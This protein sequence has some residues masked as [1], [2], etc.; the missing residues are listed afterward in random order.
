MRS[1]GTIAGM[2]ALA[3][4]GLSLPEMAGA[5]AVSIGVQT[6]NMQLGINL[7]PAPPP[8]VVVPA[9]VVV[10]GPPPPPVYYAP[11]LPYNYFVY[12]KVHYLYHEG[13]WF[14]SARYDGPWTSIGIAHVPRPILA[15]PIDHYRVRPGHWKQHGPPPWAHERVRERRWDREHG[16]GPG[17]H[18][19]KDHE[20]HRG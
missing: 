10:A 14:R 1:L 4:A 20:K 5:Q 19:D 12:G 8:L 16:H 18:A 3:I 9:P 11:S 6:T 13:R 7:G 2:L 15:V 17:S